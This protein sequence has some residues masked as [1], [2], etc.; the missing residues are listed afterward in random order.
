MTV[1]TLSSFVD[2][3][4]DAGYTRNEEGNIPYKEIEA[5]SVKYFGAAL[6][7]KTVWKVINV[8]DS[9]TVADFVDDI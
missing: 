5:R 6:P 4:I 3:V 1:K 9:R 7:N 2:S 8:I